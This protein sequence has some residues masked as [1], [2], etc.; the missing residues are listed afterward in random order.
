MPYR[1]SVELD[2]GPTRARDPHERPYRR[3]NCLDLG[4]RILRKHELRR[5][6]HH[7]TPCSEPVNSR[8]RRLVGR[9]ASGSASMHPAALPW[10]NWSTRPASVAMTIPSPSRPKCPRG[11]A[12]RVGQAGFAKR[13]LLRQP[14]PMT[15]RDRRVLAELVHQERNA[16]TSRDRSFVL[17]DSA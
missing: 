14:L 15:S 3:E 17:Q 5:R 2:T 1:R 4:A 12:R 8:D 16:G 13:N 11:N 7:L 10:W 6:S 9:Q